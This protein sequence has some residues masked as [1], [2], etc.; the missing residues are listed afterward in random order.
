MVSATIRTRT[1][2]RTTGVGEFAGD[3][4]VVVVLV[5][6]V[7]VI[8]VNVAVNLRFFHLFSSHDHAFSAKNCLLTNTTFLLT[9]DVF[10]RIDATLG[11]NPHFRFPRQPRR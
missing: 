8:D 10:S 5:V 9:S 3:V 6:A 2:R 4:V 7:V 11:V 1:S